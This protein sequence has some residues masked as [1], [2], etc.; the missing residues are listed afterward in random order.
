M[1]SFLNVKS[2]GMYSYRRTLKKLNENSF[3]MLF[4]FLSTALQGD[5][6]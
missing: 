4:D 3:V 5:L 6:K 1:Q 2:G